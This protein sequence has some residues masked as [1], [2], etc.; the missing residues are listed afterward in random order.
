MITFTVLSQNDVYGILGHTDNLEMLFLV[1]RMLL[2]N[3]YFDQEGFMSVIAKRIFG[4]A[5]PFHKVLIMAS[6]FSVWTSVFVG[7]Q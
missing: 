4:Q 2:M 1:I 6:L 5:K 3:Y 7:N